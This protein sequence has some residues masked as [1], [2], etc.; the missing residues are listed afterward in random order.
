MSVMR[1]GRGDIT[2]T[3]WERN[4]ASGMECVTKTTAALVSAQIRISSDCMR[5]RVIS[6]S[7]P[8]GS[9]ISSSAGR[10][11]SARAIATRCCIPPDSWLGRCS[12]KSESPTSSSS[13]SACAR[14]CALPTPCRP[15]GSSTLPCTVRHSSSPAD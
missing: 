10:R 13:S 2:T 8:K 15:R 7:A 5:S 4:T 9:S 14:R 6:S 11:A 12:A 1:P 3:R